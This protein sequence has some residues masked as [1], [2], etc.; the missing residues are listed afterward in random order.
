M[1]IGC[2]YSCIIY[3]IHIYEHCCKLCVDQVETYFEFVLKA[4]SLTERN[5]HGCYDHLFSVENIRRNLQ[6]CFLSSTENKDLVHVNTPVPLTLAD[7]IIYLIML[8]TPKW[9]LY[10]HT[11]PDGV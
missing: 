1:D 9:E 6:E 3:A 5:V 10:H 7:Q 8:N 4:A 2:C 11:C